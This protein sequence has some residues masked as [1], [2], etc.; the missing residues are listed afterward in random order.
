MKYKNLVLSFII[1]FSLITNLGFRK[2][3]NARYC[4]GYALENK[5]NDI[6]FLTQIIDDLHQALHFVHKDLVYGIGYSNGGF[7]VSHAA[8]LFRSIA[9]M[10]G[11][12]YDVDKDVVFD[13]TNLLTGLFHH[14][15]RD[16]PVVRF[17]GCCEQSVK[18]CCCGISKGNEQCISTEMN[19]MNWGR[20]I[21][22]CTGST[23]V[24][25]HNVESQNTCYT[26]ESCQANTVLCIYENQGHF[27][28]WW[29][30][31]IKDEIGHFFARD[32]CSLHGG[33]WS[34]K[35]KKCSCVLTSKADGIYCLNIQLEDRS[36]LALRQPNR[37]N[38]NNQSE[39]NGVGHI[40]IWIQLLSILVCMGFIRTIYLKKK[41]G[42]IKKTEYWHRIPTEEQFAEVELIST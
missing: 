5:L 20:E 9:P 31:T 23:L 8:K 4:C 25:F 42:R 26:Y 27:S 28:K 34:A 14:H 39:E 1:L 3:W 2:S 37:H 22:K 15:S 19:L 11:Y 10:A 33:E 12:Q 40:A 21:N 18:S 30:S 38:I 32:A 36:L 6:G 13:E 29:F 24:P 41:E 7:L 35:E 16:D 17:D